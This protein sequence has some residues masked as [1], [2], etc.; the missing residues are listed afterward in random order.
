MAPSVALIALPL[1]PTKNAPAAAPPIISSSSGWNREARWPPLS[2]KPPK[3][4]GRCDLHPDAPL[5]HRAD[6]NEESVSTRLATYD[7]LTRPLLDYYQKTGRL[8]KVDG[9]GEVEQI[10]AELDKLI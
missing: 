8:Q 3:T 7:E 1:L 6:D 5:V 2:A 9:R 4:D 10:Y